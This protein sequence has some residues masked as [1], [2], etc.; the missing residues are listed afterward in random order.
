MIKRRPPVT[1]LLL[2]VDAR[3]FNQELDNVKAVVA[4]KSVNKLLK[5]RKT[6]PE[7]T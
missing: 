4:I 3:L 6:H 2:D 5:D 1:V 7:A